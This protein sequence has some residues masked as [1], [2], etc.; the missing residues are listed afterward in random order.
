MLER[1]DTP[2]RETYDEEARLIIEEELKGG[3]EQWNA[4]PKPLPLAARVI[5]RLE[6]LNQS[7]REE[8]EQQVSEQLQSVVTSQDGMSAQKKSRR[9]R[10]KKKRILG[11]VG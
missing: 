10:N 8:V 4:L 7:W 1:L 5:L 3:V 11:P 6:T 9:G 2:E